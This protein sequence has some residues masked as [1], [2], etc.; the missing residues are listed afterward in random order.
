LG[1]ALLNVAG[2]ALNL[3]G[4]AKSPVLRALLLV[5]AVLGAMEL[6]KTRPWR[7]VHFGLKSSPLFLALGFAFAADLMLATSEVFNIHDGLS[8]L[9]HA[10]CADEPDRVGL[11]GTL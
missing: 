8:Y 3:L 2:G 5:G 4:L 9:R 11:E 6:G 7:K 10:R 1:L